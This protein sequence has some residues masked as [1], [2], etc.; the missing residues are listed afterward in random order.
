MPR[1]RISSDTPAW[2]RAL[3]QPGE[4]GRDTAGRGVG[5]H[6]GE[7][8]RC[9][10]LAHDCPPLACQQHID[11]FLKDVCPAQ[12]AV[13]AVGDRVADNDDAPLTRRL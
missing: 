2:L 7:S 8:V 6:D 3:R 10:A 13:V 5:L 11:P 1:N 12:S 9:A 4:S